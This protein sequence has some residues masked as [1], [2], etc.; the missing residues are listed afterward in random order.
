MK[1]SNQNS[2]S[3]WDYCLCNCLWF[4]HTFGAPLKTTWKQSKNRPAFPNRLTDTIKMIHV[5]C[6]K[7]PNGISATESGRDTRP[8]TRGRRG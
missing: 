6:W 4:I 1:R 7:I 3:F 2:L 8:T 5:S